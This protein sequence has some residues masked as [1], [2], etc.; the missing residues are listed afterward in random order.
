MSHRIRRG[1]LVGYDSDNCVTRQSMV[2]SFRGASPRPQQHETNAS[3]NSAGPHCSKSIQ[4]PAFSRTDGGRFS[5]RAPKAKPPNLPF[6]QREVP[7]ASS[8][9]LGQRLGVNS[10]R[11]GPGPLKKQGLSLTPNPTRR[12]FG[13]G[14]SNSTLTAKEVELANWKRRKNYDPMKAAQAGH[15]KTEAADKF[16]ESGSESPGEEISQR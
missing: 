1:R 16:C 5:L 3:S 15:K 7:L 11:V 12:D 4:P 8:N 6:Q 13:G 10:A 9:C 14:R 2:M